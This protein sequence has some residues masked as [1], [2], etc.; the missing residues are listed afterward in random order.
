MLGQF[1]AVIEQACYQQFVGIGIA[2]H[3]ARP[4]GRGNYIY[5][6]AKL[7]I[8]Q[9]QSFPSFGM[10]FFRDVGG[11]A[12]LWNVGIIH[13]ATSGGALVIVWIVSTAAPTPPAMLDKLK[14]GGFEAKIARLSV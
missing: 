13:R 14:T 9:R 4:V 1:S 12:S 5:G 10:R 8:G 3:Y 2:K 6:I 7:L 11:S